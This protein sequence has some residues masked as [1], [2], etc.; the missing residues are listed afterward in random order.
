[1]NGSM[2]EFKR[3]IAN[4]EFIREAEFLRFSRNKLIEELLDYDDVKD[5]EDSLKKIFQGLRRS[6][7]AGALVRA[8][9]RVYAS[10][11][12]AALNKP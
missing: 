10:Y 7:A 12:R 1:M 3:W 6:N 4:A 11:A 9:A 2:D 8:I 5:N